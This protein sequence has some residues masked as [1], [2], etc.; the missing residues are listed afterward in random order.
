CPAR[1]GPYGKAS[2]PYNSDLRLQNLCRKVEL[3]PPVQH[4]ASPDDNKPRTTVTISFH[5]VTEMK[6]SPDLSLSKSTGIQ[7]SLCHRER[8]KRPQRTRLQ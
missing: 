5:D 7:N 3:S 1:T 6:P 4:N 2:P 8:E